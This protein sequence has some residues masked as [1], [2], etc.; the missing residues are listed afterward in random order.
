VGYVRSRGRLEG[1]DRAPSWGMLGENRETLA[2]QVTT[3]LG[4][5]RSHF[6]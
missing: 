5:M 2:Q 6:A 4:L 1:R 3:K